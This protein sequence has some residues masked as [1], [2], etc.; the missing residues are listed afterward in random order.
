[1]DALNELLNAFTERF[2]SLAKRNAV[3]AKPI[4]IGDRHVLPLCELGL[5]MGAGMGQ[6]QSTEGDQGKGSGGGGGGGAK[7]TPVAVL[8]IDGNTVRLEKL[9]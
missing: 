2:T 5:G 7:V 3:V 8:V 4:S 6:G 1:M 9:G